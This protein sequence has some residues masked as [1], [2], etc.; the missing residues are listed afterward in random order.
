MIRTH[1]YPSL[2]LSIPLDPKPDIRQS[3]CKRQFLAS[4]NKAPKSLS[5][6]LGV[7]NRSQGFIDSCERG[8]F[9]GISDGS[10]YNKEQVG[11]VV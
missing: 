5:I 8:P 4:V 3:L 2:A 1:H 7:V 9:G 6:Q 10:L 11:Q